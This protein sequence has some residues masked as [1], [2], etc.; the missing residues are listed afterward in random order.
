MTD[1]LLNIDALDATYLKGE[2]SEAMRER[3][4]SH[5]DPSVKN[6][7]L[8]YILIL[9]TNK[10]TFSAMVKELTTFFEGQKDTA[11]KEFVEW[12]WKTLGTKVSEVGKEISTP[13][14]KTE[15]KLP[16]PRRRLTT[17]YRPGEPTSLRSSSDLKSSRAQTKRS[18]R[19][20]AV[21]KEDQPTKVK[22]FKICTKPLPPNEPPDS[23]FIPPPPPPRKVSKLKRKK[24]VVGKEDEGEPPRKK[25]LSRVVTST[26]KNENGL[27]MSVTS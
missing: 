26:D 23:D 5:K 3:L 10:R 17:R 2:F 14:E 11:A 7:L 4:P 22:R 18:L 19:A 8:E 12:I 27:V 9:L 24:V 15:S 21:L 6:T 16:K 13:K 25:P 1:C 20:V